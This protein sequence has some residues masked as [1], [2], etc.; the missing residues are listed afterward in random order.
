MS[1]TVKEKTRKSPK[2][3]KATTA[4]QPVTMEDIFRLFSELAR[5]Q[6][7]AAMETAR[8]Q[9]K[10]AMEQKEAAAAW[11]KRQE[12]ALEKERKEREAAAKER[13]EAAREWEA[14]TKRREEEA[15]KRHDEAMKR[16]D[17]ALKRHDEA[18]EKERKEREA[19]AKEWAKRFGYI[20]NRLGEIVEH[21]V[22]P[23]MKEQ[24]RKLNF[25]FN[26][27]SRNVKIGGQN[28]KIAA[29]LD[30][31][32]HDG[33][34]IMLIEIK[35]KPRTDDIDEHAARIKLV[36]SMGR[37]SDKNVYGAVA[38]AVWSDSVKNYALKNGFCVI[39]Q[40]GDTM[41]LETLDGKFKPKKW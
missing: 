32:L 1:T 35:T 39:E 11:E 6:K 41:R 4:S 31:V 5:E 7:K 30:C 16:H 18:L 37:Y 22:T 23:G 15:A 3:R 13:E 26:D 38:G 36:Q 29:E 17:E 10:A 27:S 40:S 14:A 21:L 34:D 8:E 25:N 19:A 2:T 28:G 24:F 12:E 33:A 9:K 20:D